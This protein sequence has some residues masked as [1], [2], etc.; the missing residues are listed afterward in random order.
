LVAARKK[1]TGDKASGKRSAKKAKKT[2]AKNGGE[3]QRIDAARRGVNTFLLVVLILV[4][5][6]GAGWMWVFLGKPG[7]PKGPQQD[8]SV[9]L[10]LYFYDS[11]VAF[12]VPVHRRVVLAPNDSKTARAV[13]EFATGP[14]D[15]SLARVYPANIPVP[16]VTVDGKTA[17]VDLPAEIVGHLGGASREGAF[18]DALTLTVTAAGEC[19]G[20]RLLVAGEQLE[21][22]G[23]GYIIENP[24]KPPEKINMASNSS[25]TG[26]TQW[27]TVY[28]LRDL[29]HRYLFPLTIE[30]PAGTPP[31]ED[32]VKALL[33]APPHVVD[34]PP[35][36]VAPSGYLLEKL[37][38]ENS[39]AR[40]DLGVPNTDT[41][42]PS[43][44]NYDINTFRRALYLTLKRCCGIEDIELSFNG[45]PVSSYERFGT[46]EPLSTNQCWN[47]EYEPPSGTIPGDSQP[48]EGGV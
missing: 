19:D 43:Y 18:L 10:E 24:L 28:Y 4:I 21:A 35:I 41:A 8:R 2:A 26:E 11:A 16:T 29:D 38:I 30:V 9:C 46:L 32:A 12:L 20:V 6:S 37:V 27:V 25:L 33:D 45:R 3:S 40:V 17:V 36:R 1:K 31:A 48:M 39:V 7:W 34:P 47:P 22:T 42:F 5:L 23:E 13:R 44:E 15:P 14:R